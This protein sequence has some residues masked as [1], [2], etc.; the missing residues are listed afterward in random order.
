MITAFRNSSLISFT[1]ILR[2]L[3]APNIWRGPTLNTSFSWQEQD[4]NFS[5]IDVLVLLVTGLLLYLNIENHLQKMF[6]FLSV[7]ETKMSRWFLQEWLCWVGPVT[8]PLK[9]PTQTFEETVQEQIRILRAMSAEY[10]PRPQYIVSQGGLQTEIE[11]LRLI[12]FKG[13]FS[14]KLF[15]TGTTS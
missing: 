15:V 1:L 7:N 3:P 14:M 11:M 13:C 8:H 6:F 12:T 10:F 2:Q 9:W 5:E 4:I